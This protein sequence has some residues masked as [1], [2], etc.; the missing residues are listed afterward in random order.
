MNIT[1][2]IGNGFDRNL[3][4]DTTYSDFVVDYKNTKPKTK[5][6]EQFH[7][8]IKENEEL[9]AAAEIAIGKYTAELET[10]AAAAFAECHTDFCER[11]AE[12]LKKQMS[13]IDY[14]DSKESILKAFS[15]LNQII[16]VFPTQER[17]ILNQV[18]KSKNSENISFNFICFNYTDTLD[19]CLSI[20]KSTPNMLG[21]HKYAGS[22]LNHSAGQIC[23]VHGTV[24]KEMVFGVNDDSQ[25][26]KV[27][28]FDCEDGDLYK[29][30]LIKIQANASYLE[31]TDAKA[32]QLIQNSQLIYIYGMSIGDTDKLWW[33][34]ICTWL[35]SSSDRHLIVQKYDMPAKTAIQLPYQLA[36]RKARRNILKH[37]TLED[38]KKNAIQTRIHITGENIFKN[39]TN[40]AKD[41]DYKNKKYLDVLKDIQ[42]EEIPKVEDPELFTAINT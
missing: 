29:N 11:L 30:M 37:S 5:V 41:I 39:I 21:S 34:R 26:S 22:V 25:I 19:Q 24:D 8:Y 23:H 1:F 38:N 28:V 12:Y 40:I 2:L 35:N 6:L 4:L 9:W 31:N 13:R 20:V 15:N 17:E 36:E 3:G 10:G 7:T 32:T 16:Q 42:T 27:D 14:S 18:Y 33:D